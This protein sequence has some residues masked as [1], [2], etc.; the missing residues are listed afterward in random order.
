MKACAVLSWCPTMVT[1]LWG[2]S[3]G[4]QFMDGLFCGDSDRHRKSLW[5]PWLGQENCSISSNSGTCGFLLLSTK[6][7]LKAQ[8]N[9]SDVCSIGSSWAGKKQCICHMPSAL[10][11][12][13][14]KWC[15][16]PLL[17]H[18][19]HRDDVRNNFQVLE[20]RA[21]LF[22][23]PQYFFFHCKT[24]KL[25]VQ[26]LQFKA[27]SFKN[28]SLHRKRDGKTQIV[29]LTENCCLISYI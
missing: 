1:P 7:H 21:N 12:I 22:I 18:C 28:L 3:L 29:N 23:L 9:Y 4:G 2:E 25:K 16:A 11:V 15:G 27:Y 10:P 24:V 26:N 13:F 5:G 17:W 19:C 8:L 6:W 20:M 14:M